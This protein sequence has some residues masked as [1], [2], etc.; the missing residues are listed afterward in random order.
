MTRPSVTGRTN[1]WQG[2]NVSPGDQRGPE[3]TPPAGA[4]KRSFHAT[5]PSVTGPLSPGKGRNGSTRCKDHAVGTIV[6]FMPNRSRSPR[7]GAPSRRFVH[8]VNGAAA[9]ARQRAAA[10][11]SA[12]HVR[13]GTRP[14]WHGARHPRAPV[15]LRATQQ[16]PRSAPAS[17]RSDRSL[18]RRV[19]LTPRAGDDYTRRRPR[20]RR[21]STRQTLRR[22]SNQH[23][24]MTPL[25]EPG[26]SPRVVGAMTTVR[27][28]S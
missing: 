21:R 18:I 4:R 2:P 17:D 23:R 15:L 20:R 13:A 14:A 19:R 24:R 16:T 3:R 8:P 11:D 12:R 22:P 6:A 7:P 25:V 9:H 28:A 26:P 27:A 10:T 1:A 5:R